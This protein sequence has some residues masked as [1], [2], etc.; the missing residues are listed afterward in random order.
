MI[1]IS[2]KTLQ[3]KSTQECEAVGH[4]GAYAP[5]DSKKRGNLK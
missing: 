3:E 1:K 2:Y 5:A 4:W